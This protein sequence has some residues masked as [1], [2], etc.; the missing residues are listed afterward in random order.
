MTLSVLYISRLAPRPCGMPYICAVDGVPGWS[1]RTGEDVGV[2][3]HQVG[4]DRR[5]VA[6]GDQPQRGVAG[7]RH[8]VVLP[9]F[10]RLTIS[11][12]VPNVLT[13]TWQPV[14]FSNG[15]T[16]ST[17]GSVEPSSAYPAQATM[18]TWPSRV[19]ERLAAREVGR[20]E[21]ARRRRRPSRRASRAAAR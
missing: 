19:P 1:F 5:D 6:G 3:R 8:D 12:E 11:S 10:I 7:G 2:V 17:V 4:V 14:S 16:Q 20:G 15:V 18:L 9:V 13:L 21:A